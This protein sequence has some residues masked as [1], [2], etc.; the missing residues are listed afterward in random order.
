MKK[1]F[2]IL[3]F[4]AFGA[5]NADHSGK[6]PVSMP[7]HTEAAIESPGQ[8][9]LQKEIQSSVIENV[10]GFSA[11]LASGWSFKQLSTVVGRIAG[12][13]GSVPF[14]IAAIVLPMA[15]A[16]YA[17]MHLI[18]IPFFKK[19]TVSDAM[20]TGNFFSGAIPIYRFEV[21]I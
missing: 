15:M 7:T 6:H 13:D 12:I 17:K 4:L 20:D 16:Y 18:S 2:F 21:G 14:N 11:G 1:Q 5:L 10:S 19:K 8:S 9:V 3:L